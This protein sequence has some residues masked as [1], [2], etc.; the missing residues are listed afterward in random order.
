MVKINYSTLLDAFKKAK[1]ELTKRSNSECV[2][3]E[4]QWQGDTYVQNMQEN[5]TT[6]N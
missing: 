1:S 3:T 5:Y 4:F 6:A 2:A